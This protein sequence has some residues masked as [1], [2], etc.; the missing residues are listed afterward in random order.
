MLIST[1]TNPRILF[2]TFRKYFLLLLVLLFSGCTTLL[3]NTENTVNGPW[4]DYDQ[5]QAIFEKIVPYKT[6]VNDLKLIGFDPKNNPN[7]KIIPFSSLIPRFIPPSEIQGY[8]VD[9]GIA[10]CIA[11]QSAC[12]CYEIEQSYEDRKRD[13]NFWLD[14]LNFDRHVNVKGWRFNAL[15]LINQDMVIY[16]LTWG[17]PKRKAYESTNNPLGPFQSIDLQKL[18]P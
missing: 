3:P 11:A 12:E 1:Y 6:S 9:K 14:V 8:R 13:G 5:A 2:S 16:K 7:V 17:E 15:L 10:E 18:G 4:E